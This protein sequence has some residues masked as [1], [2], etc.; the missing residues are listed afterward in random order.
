[1]MSATA[2]QRAVAS[3]NVG[4]KLTPTQEHE[5]RQ[6][7]TDHECWLPLFQLLDNKLKNSP[8][9]ALEVFLHK[10]RIEIKYLGDHER[11][12]IRAREIVKRF[13]VDFAWFRL[14]ILST[15]DGNWYL[16]ADVLKAVCMDFR[17]QP[18]RVKCME[19]I[20]SLYEKKIPD[21]QLLQKYY[22]DLLKI[23]PKN[24]LTLKYYKMLYSQNFDWERV[25]D[26]LRK[27]MR[28]GNLSDTYRSAQ[29]LAAVHLY[30]KNNPQE[31]LRIMQKHCA[32][33]PLDKSTILYDIYARLGNDRECVQILKR[34]LAAA[35]HPVTQAQLH[36]RIAALQEKCG[37]LDAAT[38]EYE[39]AF[40]KDP[41]QIE[42]VEKIIR[43]HLQRDDLSSVLDWL[44]KLENRATE[45]AHRERLQRLCNKIKK[46][47]AELRVSA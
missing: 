44:C 13:G 8:Q 42:V 10:I 33:S 20:C 25:I 35:R 1:M 43:T 22:R 29:E 7:L 34:K 3:I 37:R 31:A 5:A 12:A 30:S 17:A 45:R 11:V 14:K 6:L 16:E 2:V 38:Q 24:I 15:I 32:D 46:R 23:D 18:D 28:W 36:V 41:S 19:K 39:R 9:D 27:I 4:D 47:L 40:E 26:A 21:E